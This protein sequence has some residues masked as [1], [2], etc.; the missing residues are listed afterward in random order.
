[1]PRYGMNSPDHRKIIPYLNGV[2]LKHCITIDTDEG[3][4]DIITFDAE[5][6]GMRCTPWV[7]DPV[8]GSKSRSLLPPER[9]YGVATVEIL[10]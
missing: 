1:M 4:A 7:T 5:T 6:G 10:E 8:T 2:R 9:F 3:W